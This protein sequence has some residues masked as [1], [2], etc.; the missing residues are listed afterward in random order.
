[1]K[2]LKSKSANTLVWI[3]M[4]MLILGLG[5]FG[6]TNFGGGVTAI[7]SV[8]DR[9]IAVNDYARALQ[10]EMAA[11]TQQTGQTLSMEQATAFGLDRV[12]RQRLVT[13]AALDNEAARV[14]LSVGDA[15][16]LQ[17]I[18]AMPAFQG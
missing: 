8:G 12:V 7:G 4:A 2:G 9:E 18:T 5:G 6:I 15:R 13:E 14:G 1:M 16:L 3:L 10:Q 11:I 17:E